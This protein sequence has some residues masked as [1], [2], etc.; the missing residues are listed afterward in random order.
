MLIIVR[1]PGTGF[2]PHEIP[3]PVRGESVFA[4]HGRGIFLINQLMDEVKFLKNGTEI[5]MV[6]R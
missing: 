1:D 5:H 6:K 2:D 3:N 4:D